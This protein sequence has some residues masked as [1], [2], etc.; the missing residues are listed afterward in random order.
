MTLP[1]QTPP[2]KPRRWFLYAPWILSLIVVLGWSG[3]WVVLRSQL[4]SRMDAAAEQARAAGWQAE[5]QSRQISGFPFRLNVTLN[6][7]N[8]A[9]P[10]GWGIAAG[11]LR[12]ETYAYRP[13]HWVAYTPDGVTIRRPGAMPLQV[14]AKTLRASLNNLNRTPPGLS[15]EG[16][17]LSF[18]TPA[19]AQPPVFSAADKMQVHLRPGPDD[20]GAVLFRLDSAAA[21]QGRWLG[22][23][24]QGRPVTV[25]FDGLLSRADSLQGPDWASMVRNWSSAGGSLNLRTAQL[26]AGDAALNATS[27]KLGVG[28]DGRLRGDL[29]A[30][31][32]EAPMALAALAENQGVSA[33][34]AAAAAAVAQARQGGAP[35]AR[36]AINFEA[37]QMTLGPVALGPAPRIF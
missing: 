13:G 23:V 30:E 34:A 5:W 3:Y 37:G 17:G 2:R 22:R 35:L 31:L 25:V 33:E 24:A 11:Q 20:Q 10:S 29:Q 6:G 1:D 15:V 12:A 21:E 7:V 27:G 26:S 32:R 9:E 14:R 8:V 4:V 19:G 18:S 36:A 16:E 28:F